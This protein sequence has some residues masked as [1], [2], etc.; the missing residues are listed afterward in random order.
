MGIQCSGSNFVQNSSD[1]RVG[2]DSVQH[3][4]CPAKS[5]YLPA[6]R[7]A[8][9]VQ[10]AKAL[11]EDRVRPYESAYAKLLTLFAKVRIL[12]GIRIARKIP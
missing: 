9:L 7:E 12:I 3:A 1:R 8:G 2:S 4:N 5:Y 6:S 10:I 11:T